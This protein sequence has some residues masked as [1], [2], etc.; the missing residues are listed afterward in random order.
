[1]RSL[2]QFIHA[3]QTPHTAGGLPPDCRATLLNYLV[4][5][6]SSQQLPNLDPAPRVLSG[7][8]PSTRTDPHLPSSS[9]H[10]VWQATWQ[11]GHLTSC[12]C[13]L[14]DHH[15]NAQAYLHCPRHPE[16]ASSINFGLMS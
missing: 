9:L 8:V 4:L 10:R 3:A 11:A 14:L 12:L 15:M 16:T 13:F 1:M 5:F 6:P 2:L 7:T